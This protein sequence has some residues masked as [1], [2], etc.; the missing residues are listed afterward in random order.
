MVQIGGVLAITEPLLYILCN[1]SQ[2]GH[3]YSRL[4]PRNGQPSVLSFSALDLNEKLKLIII[5][6]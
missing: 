1:V 2:S 4:S 6:C 5:N 3:A